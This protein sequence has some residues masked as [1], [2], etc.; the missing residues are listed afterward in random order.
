MEK[1]KL[2]NIKIYTDGACSGNPG[3]GGY[4]ALLLIKSDIKK[5]KVVLK[6]G[7][8][9]STNNRMELKAVAEALKF[10]YVNLKG[11][12][13]FQIT[14][15]SDSSYVVNNINRGTLLKW[16][17]NGWKTTA[18]TDVA[19]KEIWVKIAKYDGLL[20][21][22]FEKVKGHS[23]NKFNNYVDKIAVQESKKYKTILEGL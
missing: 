13:K 17:R 5:D 9:H 22:S 21:A 1:G 2:L 7:E 12:Y 6:G 15:Y 18:G 3:P 4:A 16:Q 10:I 23:T 11:K 20:S 19:N 14:V 8:K